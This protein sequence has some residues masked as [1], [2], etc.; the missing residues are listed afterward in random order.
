M[1]T[2]DTR[3]KPSEAFLIETIDLLIE[4]GQP[5][6]AYNLLLRCKDTIPRSEYKSYK[7]IIEAMRQ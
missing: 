1:K 3:L 2:I 5:D 4:R 7:T 6:N